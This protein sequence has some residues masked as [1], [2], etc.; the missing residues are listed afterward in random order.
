M[1]G[2]RNRPILER[3]EEKF[4]KSAGCWEW[5]A[6]HH[7]RGYGFFHMGKTNNSRRQEYAHRMS[8]KLYVGDLEDYESV[9][10]KCDNPRCVNPDHL[11]KGSHMDNMK[12][13]REKGRY[14][15]GREK[16]TSLDREFAVFMRE[17]GVMVKDIA[18]H[19]N[20]DRGHASR[21]SRG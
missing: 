7:G 5:H 3:F 21:I 16:L 10:H 6:A 19:L 1:T 18:E 9:C 2:K 12:D 15:N 17:H 14:K 8:Y 4:T 13:M 11:F 20:I